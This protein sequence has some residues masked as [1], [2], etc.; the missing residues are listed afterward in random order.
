MEKTINSHFVSN[1]KTVIQDEPISNSITQSWTTQAVECF[2]LNS[3]CSKCSIS[4]GKYSFVCKM[5]QVVEQLLSGIGMPA[6]VS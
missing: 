6:K 1:S 3:N 2:Q 5:P 4:E